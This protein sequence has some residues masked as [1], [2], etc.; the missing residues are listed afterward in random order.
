MASPF[1]AGDHVQTPLGKGVVRELRNNG[2]VLVQVRDRALEFRGR[3]ISPLEAPSRR[4]KRQPPSGADLPAAR[5]PAPPGRAANVPLEID[6]HGLT[7][8]EALARIEQA[9]NDALLADVPELRFIHGR[10][11]GRVR[12]A[13]HRRLGEIRS[14]RWFRVDPR[15]EGVTIVGL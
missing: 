12:G 10:S 5:E 15:N 3:E 13:L 6:L 11:G 8:Q 4:G 7:V 1:S 9:L 2:R 14:V